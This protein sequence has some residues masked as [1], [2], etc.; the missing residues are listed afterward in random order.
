MKKLLLCVFLTATILKTQAL[1][2]T[3]TAVSF[4]TSTA[5]LPGSDQWA[6]VKFV[7]GSY[8]GSDRLKIYIQYK[9]INGS[10]SGQL[11]KLFD[12]AFYPF[13]FSLPDNIDGSKRI[14][15]KMPAAAVSREFIINVNLAPSTFYGIW[16]MGIP[17]AIINHTSVAKT[18]VS[19]EY[20][21]FSGRLLDYPNGLCIRKSMYKDGSMESKQVF[22][23][24]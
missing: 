4:D 19:L 5:V 17:S 10:Y 21:D 3:L 13:F 22:I 23:L 1:T 14:N 11:V 24:Q 2:L 18:T 16:E 15:F 6:D 7:S 9:S 12:T 20:F 8:T